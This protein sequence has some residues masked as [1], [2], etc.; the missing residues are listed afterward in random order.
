MVFIGLDGMG[1]PTQVVPKGSTTWMSFS[2][3]FVHHRDHRQHYSNKQLSLSI[4]RET[5]MIDR[6][7]Q[8]N[9]LHVKERDDVC[10]GRKHRA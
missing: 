5:M 10:I 6:Y 3:N 1:M 2:C 4:C 9:I 7:I 8:S